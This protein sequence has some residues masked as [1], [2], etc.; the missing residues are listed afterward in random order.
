MSD[1]I[2]MTSL[3]LAEHMG[4]Q[5]DDQVRSRGTSYKVIKLGSHICLKSLRT[6]KSYPLGILID[7]PFRRL[8]G[9]PKDEG[10]WGLLPDHRL[11]RVMQV[12]SYS[13]T[14]WQKFLEYYGQKWYIQVVKLPLGNEP[15]LFL[16]K[17]CPPSDPHILIGFW[18]IYD[19]T[20]D[21]QTKLWFMSDREFQEK[22]YPLLDEQL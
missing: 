8:R 17:G 7:K 22:V 2:N 4:L 16:D 12:S 14:S 6:G 21:P 20:L 9:I 15:V 10:M 19:K 1:V 13:D 3:E 5:I 18:L 11:V